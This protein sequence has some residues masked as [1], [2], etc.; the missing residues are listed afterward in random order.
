VPAG[1]APAEPATARTTTPVPA[2]SPRSP[3]V[4]GSDAA[5]GRPGGALDQRAS[6]PS[7]S[8]PV[9]AALQAGPR[10]SAA[11]GGSP[12]AEGEAVGVRAIGDRALAIVF[13]TNS[14]YFP[15]G[16]SQKLKALIAELAP[17]QRYRVRLQAA[18][19]GSDSV[20]G[21]SSTAEAARYNK[22]LAERRL[23]RV[24]SWLQ[25][26]VGDRELIVEPQFLAG[27]SSRRVI[28][29]ISPAG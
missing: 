27:D 23:E 18:V 22:W 4:A 9:V 25:E 7:Q 5:S 26:S 13:A 24:S 16:T 10:S 6:A 20:V 1:P 17:G 11:S 8:A 2:I 21:A 28:V 12:A 29:E 15:P 14:S 19:S 3:V